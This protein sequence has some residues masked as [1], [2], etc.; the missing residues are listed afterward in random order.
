V[1]GAGFV[2]SFR[3]YEAGQGAAQAWR[4]LFE[5]V[6]ADAQVA[7]E[8]I[9]HR[10]PQP[11][12]A[13]YKEPGLMAAFM[14]GRPF[15]LSATPMQPVAA[16]V[17]SPARYESLP[18]YCSDY[19]ARDEGDW[20]RIEDAFA[21]RFG[22]MAAD[23]Q[24]GF[25]AARNH[26]GASAFA[27]SIGPLGNPRRT[28]EALRARTVDVVAVDSYFVDLARRHDGAL[29][30]G[31]RVLASTPWTPIPLLVAAPGIDS[32]AVAR[33]REVLLQAHLIPAYAA[34]LADVLLERFTGPDI[35]RWRE[36]YA[37]PGLP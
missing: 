19:L 12:S 33:V 29:L 23:S 2:T 32:Q 17:P 9:E 8:F 24:S 34:L 13:L 35:L 3:M 5:R 21:G 28:I 10:W 26:L 14:C 4:A 27:E 1:S 20:R 36:A 16:P 31:T 15:A 6:F 18:R 25:H 30:A 37:N 7:V 11:L 22:W